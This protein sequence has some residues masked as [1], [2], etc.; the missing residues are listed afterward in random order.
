MTMMPPVQGLPRYLIVEDLSKRFAAHGRSAIEGMPPTGGR[1]MLDDAPV[2]GPRRDM[3][4]MFQQY[5]KT[6]V[7][8]P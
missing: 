7:W 4:Y 5:G 8:R 3:V 6:T 1:V 2:T